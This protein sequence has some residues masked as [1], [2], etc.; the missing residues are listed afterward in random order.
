MFNTVK[1]K[2]SENLG[3]LGIVPR[4]VTDSNTRVEGEPLWANFGMRD[5]PGAMAEV[6]TAGQRSREKTVRGTCLASATIHWVHS[7]CL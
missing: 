3:A 5:S 6:R 1:D 7:R 2:M 4:P